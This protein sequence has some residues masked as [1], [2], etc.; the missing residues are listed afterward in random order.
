M[1]EY[2]KN[3]IVRKSVEPVESVTVDLGSILSV[4]FKNGRTV[5]KKITQNVEM[6]F[7]ILKHYDCS[8]LP[9]SK[10]EVCVPEKCN[11]FELLGFQPG[12]K[13]V[14]FNDKAT[15]FIQFSS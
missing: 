8:R 13:A 7:C 2:F 3:I 4:K 10:A 14:C 15:M 9:D 6:F 1:E 5:F 11:Y 12:D